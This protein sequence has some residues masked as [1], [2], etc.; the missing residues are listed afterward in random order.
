V[1]AIGR[2]SSLSSGAN[3]LNGSWPKKICV[4]SWAP[5]LAGAEVAAER[6]AVGLKE[7][8]H[9]VFMLLGTDGE[10]LRRMR[11]VGLRCEFVPLALTDKWR[12]WRY[13]AA[14]RGVDRVL[15]RERPDLVHCN[16]LPTN[17]MVGEAAGR[18]GIPR[19]CHHRFY[20]GGTAVDW[21]NKFGAERHLFVSKALMS[22]LCAASPMLAAAPRSV[23]YDGLPL[24][25][26]PTEQDRRSARER[27]GLAQDKVH[28]LFAGQIVERKGVADLIVAW[29]LLSPAAGGRA[30]LLIAGDDLQNGGQYRRAMEEHAIRSGCPARFLGFQKNVA[31]WLLAADMAVVPSHEEP[32]GNATLEAM[33]L[34]RPVI[35]SDVGGI[36]E[37]I[38]H[39]AT[40]LLV[41]P[42]DPQKLAAAIERLIAD[43]PLREALGAAARDRCEREF[44][45]KA[46]V[47]NV[48]REYRALDRAAAAGAPV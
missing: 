47:E 41:P 37:M 6:L 45:L 2:A 30:E 32:L 10:T 44:S 18:L 46:H 29:N 11:G 36:P 39:E 33:S 17:Q 1:G 26:R 3:N 4:A 16:D 38:A 23:V 7:A 8:G 14:R 43:P 20:F 21:L 15:R 5:F 42:R 22:D 24:P 28:L 35:G 12:W 25:A 19:V 34:A 31:D 40:G 48:L 9:D 13:A 27:L